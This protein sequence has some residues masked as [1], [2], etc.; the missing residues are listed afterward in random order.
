MTAHVIGVVGG[1]GGVGAT[2][3]AA[4]LATR[5]AATGRTVACVDAD[6]LGGGL[7]VTF[8]LEQEPG[9]RWPDLAAALGRV[10]G[11]ELL[12]RLPATDGVAVLSFDRTRPGAPADEAREEVLRALTSCL[13]VVVLA[14]TRADAPFGQ[15]LAAV[16]DA[17]VLVSG[18]GVQALA[19][20]S[21]AAGFL[22][23]DND[24]L[25]LCMRSAGRDDRVAESL[26]AAVDLPLVATIGH[27]PR[28]DADLLHGI[29]PGSR[30]RGPLA[31]A[32]EAVLAALLLPAERR[33]S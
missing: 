19:G 18:D 33:A 27:D 10:G 1:S 2:V 7:D 20:T 24:Q 30:S 13:D 26:A 14:L 22:G 17:L 11:P 9:L 6:V 16:A 28:L 32:A 25:W 4:A 5:A 12:H 21:A 31:R 15:A 23:R 8:G 3:L 29:P